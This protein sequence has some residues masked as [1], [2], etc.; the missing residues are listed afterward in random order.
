MMEAL[1]NLNELRAVAEPP[2]LSL[3]EAMEAA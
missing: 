2:T 1:L 3:A